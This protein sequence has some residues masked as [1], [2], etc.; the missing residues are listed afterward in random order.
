MKVNLRSVSW[1][2]SGQ[3]FSEPPLWLVWQFAMFNKLHT[4]QKKVK[5]SFL[6]MFLEHVSPAVSVVRPICGTQLAFMWVARAR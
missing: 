5:N 3:T 4:E 6:N 2:H 1:A